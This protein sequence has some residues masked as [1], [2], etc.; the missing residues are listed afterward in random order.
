MGEILINNNFSNNLNGWVNGVDGG[1]AFGWVD[2]QAEAISYS[3]STSKKPHKIWQLLSIEA[4][5]ISATLEVFARWETYGGDIVDGSVEFEIYIIRP[6]G[7]YD[8]YYQVTYTGSSEAKILSNVNVL[9][10]F[11]AGGIGTYKLLL[12]ASPASAKTGSAYIQSF[13]YYDWASLVVTFRH[14]KSIIESLNFSPAPEKD[15]SKAMSELVKPSESISQKVWFF[16]RIS[17]GI[18]LSEILKKSSFKSFSE[19]VAN[20]EQLSSTYFDVIN[21]KK[22]SPSESINILEKLS[23]RDVSKGLSESIILNELTDVYVGY[24]KNIEESISLD[25][26]ITPTHIKP[27]SIG[28]QISLSEKIVSIIKTSGNWMIIYTPGGTRYSDISP[29]DNE[30]VRREARIAHDIEV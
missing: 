12:I 22:E 8:K 7:V 2:G 9:P 25:E 27:R 5:V 13:G 23:D 10:T 28:E 19:G 20:T 29:V 1:Y 6:D 11:Q 17:E 21:V 16:R 26:D 24:F 14:K 18:N 30:W 15:F 4:E 3:D